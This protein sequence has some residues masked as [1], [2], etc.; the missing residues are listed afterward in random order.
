MRGTQLFNG[1]LEEFTNKTTEKAQRNVPADISRE[2]ISRDSQLILHHT[3]RMI[4][5]F[6]VAMMTI[7]VAVVMILVVAVI[8]IMVIAVAIRVEKAN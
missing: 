6:I 1:R 8:L 5:I 7:G 3:I 2:G 4:A